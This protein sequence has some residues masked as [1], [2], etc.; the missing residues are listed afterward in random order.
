MKLYDAEEG[1][2]AKTVL[3][4]K[5]KLRELESEDNLRGSLTADCQARLVA[6]ADTLEE[7]LEVLYTLLLLLFL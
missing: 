1:K 5:A 2:A 3:D 7:A 6:A 4:I